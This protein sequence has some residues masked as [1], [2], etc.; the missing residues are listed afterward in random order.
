MKY[1]LFL[2]TLLCCNAQAASILVK[3]VPA[4]QHTDSTAI[5]IP[6]SYKVYAGINGHYKAFRTQTSALTWLFTGI[7][8]GTKVCVVVTTIEWKYESHQSPLVC[9]TA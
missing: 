4:T 3:W 8:P 6:V 1:A 5:R 9:M 7:T 2:A